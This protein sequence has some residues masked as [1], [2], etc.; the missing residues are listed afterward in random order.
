MHPRSASLCARSREKEGNP[1]HGGGEGEVSFRRP[2]VPAAA[3]ARCAS[4][5]S[6]RE[7]AERVS[8]WSA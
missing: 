8:Q 3:P 5:L 4:T 7:R 2:N 1:S 6:P